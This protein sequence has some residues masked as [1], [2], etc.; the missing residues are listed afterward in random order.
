MVSF[1][2]F[3]LSQDYSKGSQEEGIMLTALGLMPT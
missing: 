1:A 2:G 3:F